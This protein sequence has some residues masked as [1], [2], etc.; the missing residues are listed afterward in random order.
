M[1]C[2]MID[3]PDKYIGV[4]VSSNSLDGDFFS[5]KFISDPALTRFLY[6]YV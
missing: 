3:D 6:D 2:E 1:P 4:R 5:P